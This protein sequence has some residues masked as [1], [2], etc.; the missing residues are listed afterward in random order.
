V[1]VRLEMD[2]LQKVTYDEIMQKVKNLILFISQDFEYKA[3]RLTKEVPLEI[4]IFKESLYKVDLSYREILNQKIYFVEHQGF[5]YFK[6]CIQTCQDHLKDIEQVL[7]KNGIDLSELS[8]LT[9]L[10]NEGI[11]VQ[12]Q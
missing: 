2:T 6:S 4:D 7:S 10:G 12:P 1:K 5:G 8:D 9:R 11:I 3:Y